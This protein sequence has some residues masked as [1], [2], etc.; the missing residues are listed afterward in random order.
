MHK[1]AAKVVPLSPF[2]IG[3]AF[4]CE[5]FDCEEPEPA[6]VASSNTTTTTT[7]THHKHFDIRLHL[8]F[9]A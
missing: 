1:R 9:Q 2:E 7:T 8:Q 4:F 5:D 3:H 6:S